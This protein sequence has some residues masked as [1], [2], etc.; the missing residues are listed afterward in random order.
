MNVTPAFYAHLITLLGGVADGKLLAVLEGGYFVP[1]LS[2]AAFRTVKALLNDPCPPL[3]YGQ[4]IN[5]SVIDSINNV[6]VA[7]RPYWKCF[8]QID[9]VKPVTNLVQ[10]D[11]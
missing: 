3:E 10:Y 6:K 11:R 5:K 4:Q 9:S 2:E 7:L 1:S 8:K